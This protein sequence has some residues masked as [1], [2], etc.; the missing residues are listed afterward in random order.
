MFNGRRKILF[1]VYFFSLGLISAIVQM[2][3]LRET[4][5]SFRGNELFLTYFLIAWLIL[6][7]LG[8]LLFNG[9]FINRQLGFFI[10]G[11][12]F[13]ISFFIISA[14]LAIRLL[15]SMLHFSGEVPNLFYSLIGLPVA[16]LPVTLFLGL[17]FTLGSR[18]F[19]NLTPTKN[20]LNI[21]LA[22]LWETGGFFLGSFIFNFWLVNLITFKLILFLIIYCLFINLLLL[23]YYYQQSARKVFWLVFNLLFIFIISWHLGAAVIYENKTAAWRI[24]REKLVS[25]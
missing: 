16:I 9:R 3:L 13:I 18:Y 6:I 8:S 22:Y 24:P 19:Y 23:I 17:G 15:P 14:F 4:L 2:I 1:A 25:F 7:S 10:S 5:I 12:Y 21:N 20:I 11:Y